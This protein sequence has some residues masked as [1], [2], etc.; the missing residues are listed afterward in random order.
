M[1]PQLVKRLLSNFAELHR[2]SQNF[3]CFSRLQTS[4]RLRK[5]LP[6]MP[7]GDPADFSQNIQNL[8]TAQMAQL[9]GT[10][11]AFGQVNNITAHAGGG[12]AAAFLLTGAINRITTVATTGDSVKLPPAIAPATLHIVNAAAA[13]TCN[14][15]PSTGDQVSALGPNIAFPLPA[16][17]MAHL[18]C[19]NNGQWHVN[20]S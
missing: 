3:A 17:K 4:D 9:T 15:F 8:T 7:Q 1:L 20:L 11:G 16:G 18:I 19:T 12:Q 6:I 13:N 2:T 10:T 14:V 5:G